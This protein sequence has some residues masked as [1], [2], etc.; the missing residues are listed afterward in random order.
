VRPGPD[1]HAM[2]PPDRVCAPLLHSPGGVHDTSSS[3]SYFPFTTSCAIRDRHVHPGSD[4]GIVHCRRSRRALEP[5]RPRGET[6]P[7]GRMG[8]DSRRCSERHRC[9]VLSRIAHSGSL[10][11]HCTIAQ[12][13]LINPHE[14]SLLP[15]RGGARPRDELGHVQP[16][17]GGLGRLSPNHQNAFLDA[18]L[19]GITAP[20]TLTFPSRASVFGTPFDLGRNERISPVRRHPC[21]SAPGRRTPRRNRRADRDCRHPAADGWPFRTEPPPRAC[22]RRGRRPPRPSAGRS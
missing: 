2:Y 16:R 13:V 17:R 19:V 12:G 8:T 21:R 7:Y 6:Y 3:S 5:I 1:S 14:A 9:D 15:P 18:L 22:C 20:V 4:A 10:H 11:I